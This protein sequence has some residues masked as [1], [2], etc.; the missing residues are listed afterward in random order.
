MKIAASFLSIKNGIKK[1]VERLDK[2]TIDYLHVDIMDGKFVPNKTWSFRQVK[3][4]LK[5]TT[6][7]KDIHLMVKDVKKYINKYKKMRPEIITFHYEATNEWFEMIRILKHEDIKAGMSIKP[8]TDI[9]KIM[10][11][12]EYLDVV[13]VM[14]VEPGKGGQS[15]IPSSIKKIQ[16]LDKI[17]KEKNYQFAIEV[18]GGVNDSNFKLLEEN[19]VDT[20]VVGS[21]L[22]KRRTFQKNIDSLRETKKQN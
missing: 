3:H 9:S 17:R 11:Y 18:D 22:A 20:V 16:E 4:I 21:Y 15:F 7:P 2:T 13:L 10:P 12:L 8:N 19:N 6:T 5:K 1:N 14:S